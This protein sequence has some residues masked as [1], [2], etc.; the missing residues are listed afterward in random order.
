MVVVSS[1]RCRFAL[2]ADPP[3]LPIFSLQQMP[4]D[5]YLL[6]N[7]H[8]KLL[9]NPL[10]AEFGIEDMAQMNHFIKKQM[11]KFKM[12]SRG[13]RNALL[14]PSRVAGKQAHGKPT[15][16]VKPPPLFLASLRPDIEKSHIE[17]ECCVTPRYRRRV[18]PLS[19]SRT[20]EPCLLG[21]EPFMFG[22]EPFVFGGEPFVFG[23][24]PC[25]FS[26]KP[27]VPLAGTPSR[28]LRPS[29]AAFIAQPGGKYVCRPST[30]PYSFYIPYH[31][32]I[33]PS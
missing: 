18:P 33:K 10:A 25:V 5:E 20:S 21:G 1:V 16:V 2:I 24:E 4:I 13:L 6:K 23:G 29:L 12:V 15:S 3:P 19:P 11:P 14:Y 17:Q 27:C 26:G 9:Y 31:V 22:G 28:R 8:K 30:G 32:A 7:P